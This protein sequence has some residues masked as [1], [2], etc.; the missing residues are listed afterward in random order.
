LQLLPVT[1]DENGR[2]F[3]AFEGDTHQLRFI[4]PAPEGSAG[5]AY[6]VYRLGV[7]PLSGSSRV[8]LAFAPFDP[9]SEQF[10]MAEISGKEVLTDK[11]LD[12]SFEYFGAQDEH[13][14]PSW[15]AT[16]PSTTGRVPTVVRMQLTSTALQWPDLLFQI[17]FE[18]EG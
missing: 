14:Q 13:D 16:W 6:L 5:P 8:T 2:D 9:G 15:H 4:G 3:V 11:L 18:A 7:E 12:A 17:H 1:W 10:A